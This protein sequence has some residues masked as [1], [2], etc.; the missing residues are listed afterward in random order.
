MQ[1]PARLIVSRCRVDA[2]Y[3]NAVVKIYDKLDLID[4][5]RFVLG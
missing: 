3:K 1:T 2:I 5:D 4:S